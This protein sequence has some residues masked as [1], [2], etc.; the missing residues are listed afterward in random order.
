M[1]NVNRL[2]LA[3]KRRRFTAKGLAEKAEIAPVTLSRI[4]KGKQDPDETTII[5]LVRALGFPRAFFERDDADKIEVA[6]ASFRSMSGMTARERDAALSAGSL[7]Y[8]VSDWVD[9]RYELPK[10]D[11]LDLEYGHLE[12]AA[13]ARMLRQHWS[14]GERPLGSVIKLL[15]AKGVRI[16]SLSESTKN[17]DAFSVWRDDFPFVFLNTFKTA[18]RSRFDAMHELGH[19]ILHRHGGPAHREAEQE[20]NQFASSMLMPSADV[21]AHLP[22]VTS[23]DQVIRAKRRWGVSAAALSYR[24]HKLGIISDWQY[25]SF[26]IQ[27]N[28]LYKKSEPA[29]MDREKSAIW[30]MVFQD[31]WKERVT[32]S[33]IAKQLHIPDQELENLVFGLTGNSNQNSTDVFKDGLLVVK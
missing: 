27:L 26:C 12:P 24:L 2:E 6:S 18:E 28:Q 5:K 13:A 23:L 3:R 29:P 7:A 16:F 25:R 14:I 22:Y 21:R 20:A 1:F 30:Q 10:M 19:L 31:L 11:L 9:R 8:E 32:R 33:E 17:V 4:M 15:E